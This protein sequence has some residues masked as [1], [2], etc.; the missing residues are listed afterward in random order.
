[1]SKIDNATIGRL[2]HL[3]T[4]VDPPSWRSMIEGRDRQSG[5][6]FIK[7]GADDD[8]RED[9]YVSRDGSPADGATLDLIAE[10]RNCLPLLIAEIARLRALLVER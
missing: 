10:A 9:L 3:S 8:R 6:S 4:W 2:V 1:V 7:V 5:D